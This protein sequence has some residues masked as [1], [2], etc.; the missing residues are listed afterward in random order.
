MVD[1]LHDGSRKIHTLQ[2]PIEHP[3]PSVFQSQINLAV[4][5]QNFGKRTDTMFA[6]A[7]ASQR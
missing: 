4:N 5:Q 2:V 3:I 6:M 1:E 7:T